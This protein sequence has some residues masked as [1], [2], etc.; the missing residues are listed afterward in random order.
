MYT[1]WHFVNMFIPFFLF[2]VLNCEFWLF[3]LVDVS[4]D[5]NCKRACALK[6][7]LCFIFVF[8]ICVNFR[9]NQFCT[10]LVKKIKYQDCY[11]LCLFTGN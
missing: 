5:A 11:R 10:V 3:D 2:V 7:N 9:L 1:L 8:Y 4:D 6:L